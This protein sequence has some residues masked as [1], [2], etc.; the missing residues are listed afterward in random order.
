MLKE[1]LGAASALWQVLSSSP[2]RDQQ[3]DPNTSPRLL[4]T[5]LILSSMIFEQPPAAGT[6]VPQGKKKLSLNDQDREAGAADHMERIPPFFVSRTGF[7]DM[8]I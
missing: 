4:C 2:R 8:M 5:I 1:D 6:N 7:G 3:L